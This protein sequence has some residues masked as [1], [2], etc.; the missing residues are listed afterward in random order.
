MDR[1][2]FI[3]VAAACPRLCAMP[4]NLGVLPEMTATGVVPVSERKKQG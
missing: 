2:A 4:D 3:V 1:A